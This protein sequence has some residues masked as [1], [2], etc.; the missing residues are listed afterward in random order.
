MGGNTITE[1]NFVDVVQWFLILFDQY[2]LTPNDTINISLR[3]LTCIL[4]NCTILIVYTRKVVFLDFAP[5]L[6]FWIQGP[7]TK[8]PFDG[9]K[10]FLF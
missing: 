7:R 6:P 9:I 10:F 1:C 5:M 2:K 8:I 4:S 3:V